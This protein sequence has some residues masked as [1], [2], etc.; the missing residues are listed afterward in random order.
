[1]IPQISFSKKQLEYIQ[2]ANHR[3]N[4]KIGATRSGKTYLDRIWTIPY[5]IMQVIDK[6]GLVFVCGVSKSTIERNILS[7]MRTLWGSQLVGEINS[8]NM[9]YLFGEWCY[10]LGTEKVSQVSKFRGAD[11]KYLYID[12]LPE[13]HPDVFSILQTRLSFPY[14]M[15]DFTGNP[16]TPTHWLKKFIDRKDLDIFI[17]SLTIFDNPFLSEQFVAEICKELEGTVFYDRYILGK[18]KR[19]E[20]AIYIKFANNPENYILDKVP[21]LLMIE[22]GVDFGGNK[23]KTTFVATGYTFGFRDLIVLEAKK[24]EINGDPETLNKYFVEFVK[25]VYTKYGRAF[26]VNYDNAEPILGNGLTNAAAKERCN[27]S[28]YPAIKTKIV[29]RIATET[30]L[31]GAGRFW[32]MRWATNV[33]TALSDAVYNDKVPDER[34]DNGTSDIDTLDALEYSFEKHIYDLMNAENKSGIE[35]EKYKNVNRR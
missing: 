13:C 18:W 9:V 11:V 4:G 35:K 12:E 2:K 5:R 25:D 16:T 20:G 1:M 7:P 21:P 27:V 31:M 32:V 17:Q 33:V 15:C 23:S 24:M 19:A 10:A 22:C 14:S 6:D 3:W 28:V 8:A 26:D 30:R 34:L 29:N